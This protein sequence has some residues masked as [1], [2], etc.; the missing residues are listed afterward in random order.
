MN[1]QERSDLARLVL[2]TVEVDL[3]SGELKGFIPKPAFAPLFRVLAEEEGWL[4]NI[5]DW[6]PRPDSNR[7]S[8][9]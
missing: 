1:L 4:I 2:A 9:P 8:P 3:R 5:C 7:R 6:R